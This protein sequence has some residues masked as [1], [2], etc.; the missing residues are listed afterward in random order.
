VNARLSASTTLMGNTT[1]HCK[2]K[3]AN[4]KSPGAHKGR[5]G[6]DQS[7][8]HGNRKRQS[9]EAENGSQNR[10]PNG[11]RVPRFFWT[12]KSCIATKSERK[13]PLDKKEGGLK[14]KKKNWFKGS[15]TRSL[16]FPS[17]RQ[18]GY[19]VLG[20]LISRK[21]PSRWEED[22]TGTWTRSQRKRKNGWP[23]LIAKRG[24]G[25]IA[26]SKGFRG[27]G[28]KRLTDRAPSG[29]TGGVLQPKLD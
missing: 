2:T 19:I 22:P 20:L 4:E 3:S 1:F 21:V 14:K 5:G 7:M 8:P 17:A 16:A 24:K 9:F 13:K 18:K 28:K 11:K 27:R 12:R 25:W 26:A 23:N 15:E 29:R 6:S 10:N